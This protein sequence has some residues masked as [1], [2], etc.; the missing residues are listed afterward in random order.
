MINISEHNRKAWNRQCREGGPWSRPVSPEEIR[1][2]AHGNPSIYLT[3]NRPLPLNW[4]GA[5]K[6]AQVLCLASAGGQQAPLLAAAGAKVIS[7]DNSDEQL[8]RDREVADRDG[9]QLNT[10]RGDMQDLSCF[11]NEEFDLI[12]HAVSNLFIPH[13]RPLWKSCAR[14][15]K[16]GGCCLA[17]FLNPLFYLFDHDEAMESGQLAV[18]YALPYSDEKCLP[19]ATWQNLLESG[20]TLQFGHSLE[21]Q[22]A[23]QIEAGLILTGF[24]E[25]DWNDDATPLNRYSPMYIVTKSEKR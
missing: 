7:F 16:P 6:D 5:L 15:L 3:P 14:I 17:G 23:G 20:Q 8:A 21:D 25:D 24:Y 9:L 2:A 10:I 12:I 22:I 4:L 13:I 1:A 18:K 11:Q 19:P